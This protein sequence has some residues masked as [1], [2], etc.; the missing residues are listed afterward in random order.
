MVE[1]LSPEFK[2]PKQQM[3]VGILPSEV[4]CKEGLELIFKATDGSPACV[5]P[6]TAEILFERGWASVSSPTIQKEQIKKEQTI[7]EKIESSQKC[8]IDSYC[9]SE[10]PISPGS[11]LNLYLSDD[12]LNLNRSGFDTVS[13]Q[14]LLK[15][16]INGIEILGPKTMTETSQ[17]S[18]VFLIKLKI[19]TTVNG[20]PVNNGD[21]VTIQYNDE[22]D[23]SGNPQSI[24]QSIA[25]SK[26]FSKLAF[27]ENPRIGQKFTVTL[28]EP[29]ANL[30][31][32]DV[33]RI[34]LNKIQFRA[35][36]G[37]RTTLA[38]TAFDANSS[39]LLETGKNTNVF[40]VTI[41]IPRFIDGKVVH[42][43]SW[44]ELTYIDT[45]SPS[46][47]AEE[48]EVRGRIG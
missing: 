20:E 26:S 39:F 41:E 28:Y 40:V 3:K 5:K 22:S 43:G 8:Y 9:P 12:D 19:P 25:I 10:T 11:T 31:S 1:N 29:D 18:G 33:D 32:D 14:V 23:S 2:T 27:K 36:N 42:I 46:E 4:E 45:T 47:S 13:T 44:F 48:I 35:N 16:T 15:F 7:Q 24:S 37:I 21:I 17:N 6:R 34:P 30:D 38:N